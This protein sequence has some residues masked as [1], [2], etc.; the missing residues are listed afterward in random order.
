[1][2]STQTTQ[3]NSISGPSVSSNFRFVSNALMTKF[4]ILSKHLTRSTTINA[5]S[6]EMPTRQGD[7]LSADV[8][9]SNLLHENTAL[10]GMLGH[11]S[12]PGITRSCTEEESSRAEPLSLPHSLPHKDSL[13][14]PNH[15]LFFDGIRMT[16]E[17]WKRQRTLDSHDGSMTFFAPSK[18][19]QLSPSRD[20]HGSSMCISNGGDVEENLER[21]MDDEHCVVITPADQSQ[22]STLLMNSQEVTDSSFMQQRSNMS[23]LLM[24]HS[25]ENTPVECKFFNGPNLEPIIGCAPTE[26]SDQKPLL[27][28]PQYRYAQKLHHQSLKIPQQLSF[29]LSCRRPMSY[30]GLGRHNQ[31]NKNLKNIGYRLGK[32]KQ[33]FKRRCRISDYALAF[34]LFGIL[35]M[36]LESE[37]IRACVYAKK[38]IYSILMRSLITVSTF[39]LIGLILGYHVLVIKIFSCDD[40]IED[41][42]IAID[43][44]RMMQMSLEVLICSIH[45]FPN[46]YS[47]LWPVSPPYDGLQKHN[48]THLSYR[49][50]MMSNNELVYTWL[51]LTI[52]VCSSWKILHPPSNNYNGVDAEVYR[53]TSI[54]LFLSLPMFLRL[55]LIFRV[56]LLHSRLFTDA[57][58]RSIGAMNKVSFDT[59]FVLKTMMTLSPATVLLSFIFCLW[60]IL[61]WMLRACEGIHDSYH[62]NILNSMWLIAV[63]FLSIGYGDLVP[64]TYC[65]RTIAI[66]AGVMGSSCTALVVAVFARKL[67]LSK[68]EKH[69]I[70]F[71]MENK[72]TK[73]VKYYAANVLRETWLIYKYTKLAKRVNASKV[74]THQ[75]KFLRAIHG[76]RQTKMDHRKVQESANTL[77]DLA[78]TQYNIYEVV[79]DIRE[80]QKCNQHRMDVL[81]DCLLKMQEQMNTLPAVLRAMMI[82]QPVLHQCASPVGIVSLSESR[83]PHTHAY[84]QTQGN[85]IKLETCSRPLSTDQSSTCLESRIASLCSSQQ[86][87][88]NRPTVRLREGNL[89]GAL[90]DSIHTSRTKTH[91]FNKW[92]SVDETDL[93]PI[94][95][96]FEPCN[97]AGSTETIQHAKGK[98]CYSESTKRRRES[99]RRTKKGTKVT[100]GGVPTNSV[101]MKTIHSTEQIADKDS[102]KNLEQDD[103]VK[104]PNP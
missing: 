16:A 94:P 63:T 48:H 8:F 12:A 27:D 71:M 14:A 15:C 102:S 53:E 54:D 34:A 22:E 74:R 97:Y 76:L 66:S 1:M 99:F 91:S 6:S 21:S 31:T 59:Q 32:R 104:E 33:L 62:R 80:E 87:G 9:D 19:S 36:I 57:G 24:N 55:Y 23:S 51:K 101:R 95:D 37:L 7:G 85:G 10:R 82:Q 84:K 88:L 68:A 29:Y 67:E 70:H 41:W 61:S 89:I 73:Q 65:G 13:I 35:L 69:V 90:N 17:R 3:K 60:I 100:V 30:N 47:F 86:G 75:R 58:S 2:L 49:G 50:P 44:Q 103:G 92:N 25:T 64:N 26:N 79:A 45:P 81:E 96:Q 78:K 42:R 93:S 43:R 56:I 98:F 39:V 4:P 5:T 46:M 20:N 77:V 72:L 28:K 11:N 83:R 38:D 40:S 52:V 18:S